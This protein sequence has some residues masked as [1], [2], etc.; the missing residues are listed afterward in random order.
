MS[1]KNLGRS[2]AHL[3][4]PTSLNH[5]PSCC[6]TGIDGKLC[7]GGFLRTGN[8]WSAAHLVLVYCEVCEWGSWP[9]MWGIHPSPFNA[10]SYIPCQSCPIRWPCW[11]LLVIL[12]HTVWL[13]SINL[14]ISGHVNFIPGQIQTS[15]SL[16][17]QSNVIHRLQDKKSSR[18]SLFR[19]QCD[20]NLTSSELLIYVKW[21]SLQF[22]LIHRP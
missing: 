14:V 7:G 6:E 15:E 21:S 13:C 10:I 1:I 3:L 17:H 4:A 22:I 12:S 5:N 11:L 9:W 18:E 16:I 19:L 8:H 2:S 20:T